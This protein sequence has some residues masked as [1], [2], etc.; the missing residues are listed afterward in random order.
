MAKAKKHQPEGEAPERKPYA[1]M[2]S[3]N[4]VWTDTRWVVEGMGDDWLEQ[5]YNRKREF[6]AKL[7]DEFGDLAPWTT[8]IHADKQIR[9]CCGHPVFLVD[10]DPM[11]LR[12]WLDSWVELQYCRLWC[13]I[14]DTLRLKKGVREADAAF[15]ADELTCEFE[16]LYEPTDPR[17]P[18][19]IK[20][21]GTK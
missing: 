10:P 18:R 19:K 5:L 20:K 6:Y 21:R 1:F 7:H 8:I 11:F 9:Y 2:D 12:K 14:F 13:Q 3:Y 4:F 16:A 17:L 15:R